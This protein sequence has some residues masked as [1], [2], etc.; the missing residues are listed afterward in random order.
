MLVYSIECSLSIVTGVSASYLS[1]IELGTKN[2]TVEIL[3][4]ICNA[5]DITLQELLQE[6]PPS[7]IKPE[8]REIA[9]TLSDFSYEDIQLLNEFLKSVAKKFH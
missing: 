9:K 1:E 3:Q 8:V 5:F 6:M 4:K 7:P 2:P